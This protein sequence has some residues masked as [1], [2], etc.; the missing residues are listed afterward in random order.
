MFRKKLDVSKD[1]ECEAFVAWAHEQMGGLNGLVN[2]AGILRDG[3]LVK[4]DRT[5]GAIVKLTTDQWNAVI[6]VNPQR[7]HLHG[8]RGRRQDGR[9]RPPP[10]RHR[11]HVE[12]RL[13]RQSWPVQLRGAPLGVSRRQHRDVGPRVS[14]PR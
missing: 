9:R 12:R 3:L 2:N 8:P 11:Q 4:K 6:G 5:T 13:P 14:C 1:T 10:R 7:R